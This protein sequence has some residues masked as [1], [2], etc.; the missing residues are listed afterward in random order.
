L[1]LFELE[2]VFHFVPATLEEHK[3]WIHHKNDVEEWYSLAWVEV[4][5][6]D[7]VYYQIQNT[8]SN[9]FRSV[10]IYK[11]E[12]IHDSVPTFCHLWRTALIMIRWEVVWL[13]WEISPK[14]ANNFGIEKRIWFFEIEVEKLENALYQTIKAKD[15]SNFQENEFDLN[16][17]VDK[18]TKASK[19]KKTI[20][21]TNQIITKVELTD[22]YENK[23][24]LTW[25]RSLTYKI[26][27]QSMEKT[28]DDNDKWELIK[29][30]VENVKKV[31][32]E[33]RS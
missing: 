12:F 4:F 20:E 7:V 16:F 28:L 18:N 8:I 3:A 5:D 17:V 11:F 32:G 22:I 15:V 25:K 1:K 33:L 10:W 27:I 23:D 21:T 2:K 24:K 9:F 26:Y 14:V 6:E 19:I 31:G 30:I 13:I 29:K